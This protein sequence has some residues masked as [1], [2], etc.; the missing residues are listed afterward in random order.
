MTVN[1]NK[2]AWA[3]WLKDQSE[4]I[5][6]QTLGPGRYEILKR[7]MSLASMVSKSGNLIPLKALKKP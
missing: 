6:R 5:Q 1:T 7:G 3:A 2:L 4:K